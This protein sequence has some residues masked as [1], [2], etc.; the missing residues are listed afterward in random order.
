[1]TDCG[2]PIDPRRHAVCAVCEGL[3][4]CVDCAR[5]H[6]CTSE[7]GARGC[8]PGLC[9]KEVRDGEVAGEFGLR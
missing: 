9:V 6:F 7:C 2:H 5:K 4:L 1:M 8:T 3:R